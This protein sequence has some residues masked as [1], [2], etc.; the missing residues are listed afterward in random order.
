MYIISN[1]GSYILNNRV[2]YV[3]YFYRNFSIDK[4][5]ISDKFREFI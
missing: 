4:R 3:F 2:I 5:V 1:M